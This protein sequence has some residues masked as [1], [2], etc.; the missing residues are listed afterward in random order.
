MTL[1]CI[2]GLV[3]FNRERERTPVNPMAEAQAMLRQ[4]VLQHNEMTTGQL[5]STLRQ[6]QAILGRT[7]RV[8]DLQG[9]PPHPPH[10]H[11]ALAGVRN[12]A[13]EADAVSLAIE[14]GGVASTHMAVTALLEAVDRTTTYLDRMLADMAKEHRGQLPQKRQEGPHLELPPPLRRRLPSRDLPAVHPHSQPPAV[15]VPPEVPAV[16]ERRLPPQYQHGE[17]ASNTGDATPYQVL[18]AQQILERLLPF[19]EQEAA[20]TLSE[21]HSLLFRWTSALWGEAV[22]LVEEEVTQEGGTSPGFADTTPPTQSF[23]A[24]SPGKRPPVARQESHRRRRL[25]AAL[26]DTPDSNGGHSE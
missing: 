3:S 25:H 1:R 19:L 17:A 14:E 12:A 20:A 15:P 11:E 5:R 4:L 24:A 7:R 6:V 16:H 8:I 18:K 2:I 26:L 23:W 9:E 21:A 13:N 10:W 22:L